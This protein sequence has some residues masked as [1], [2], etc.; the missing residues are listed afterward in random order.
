MLPG[1]D[2]AAEIRG[3]IRSDIATETLKFKTFFCNRDAILSVVLEENGWKAQDASG[4]R[5][6]SAE[7]SYWDTHGNKPEVDY[8]YKHS[9]AR[10]DQPN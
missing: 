6:L 5:P 8:C 4:P 2:T 9:A 3:D 10:T 7:I 1:G